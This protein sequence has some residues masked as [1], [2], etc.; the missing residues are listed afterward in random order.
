[1]VRE[2]VVKV[3]VN[4]VMINYYFKFKEEL[5]NIF[6]KKFLK[7]YMDEYK[8]IYDIKNLVFK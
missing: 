7:C 6:I 8:V 1:M 5:I 4:L 3:N 2:I